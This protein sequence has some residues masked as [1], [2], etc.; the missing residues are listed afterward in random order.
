MPR[1]VRAYLS[2]IIDSCDAITAAVLGLD[3]VGYEGNRLVNL[4]G[5]LAIAFCR[6]A[7]INERKVPAMDLG[8]IS[9]TALRECTQQVQR[10]RRL[11]VGA[12]LALRIRDAG[13]FGEL[14][15]IDHV[16]AI[17]WQFNA[18]DGFGIA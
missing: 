18:I 4:G 10:R 2:D 3:L 17:A 11:V 7:A 15:A 16:T 14:D 5:Q 12:D 1:D 6:R 13:F 9:K 8:Q